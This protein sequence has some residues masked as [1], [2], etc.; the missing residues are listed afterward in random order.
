MR[1]SKSLFLCKFLNTLIAIEFAFPVKYRVCILNKRVLGSLLQY[2]LSTSLMWFE[3][4]QRWGLIK[5][6]HVWITTLVNYTCK[7]FIK[8]TLVPF[9]LLNFKVTPLVTKQSN[10][11]LPSGYVCHIG[12]QIL[13]KYINILLL[14]SS[15]KEDHPGDVVLQIQMYS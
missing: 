7:N 14:I 4:P 11:P 3:L 8:M 9:W 10:G 15:Y 12:Y 13:R 2:S 5:L 1:L 6:F